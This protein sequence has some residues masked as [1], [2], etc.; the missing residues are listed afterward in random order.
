ML[1][2]LDNNEENL[3]NLEQEINETGTNINVKPTLGDIR[4]RVIMDKL[5]S[6]NRPQVVLHAAAYKHVPM[7]ELNPWY[8]VLT[9]VEGTQ[10]IV[11]LSDNYKV[12]KFILVSTDKAVHPV[13]VMG[14]T[15]RLSERIIQTV[16]KVSQTQYMAVRFGNVIGSSGS[17]IPTLKRQI[18]KGGPI[19]I[20]HPD[21]TRYFM[22]IP[23]A[24]QLIL[25]TGSI[26]RGGEI[27]VLDMGR[28]IKIKN[29]AYDLIRLSGFEPEIEI[30]VIYTGL[31]PGEKM[32][33]ELVTREEKVNKTV[34]PKILIMK[35][36]A[37]K[38]PW[39]DLKID[40]EKL[41]N[42]TLTFNSNS[43]KQKLQQMMPE[44]EPLDYSPPVPNEAM[45]Q[46]LFEIE[47][48]TIKG[49]A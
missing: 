35:N 8:A 25:Q 6:E 44:Y 26:G 9:N 30:P 14:A 29:M 49:Q 5:F 22:S 34:H 2:L 40:I 37:T 27:F 3:F 46:E 28:P 23:E 16:D 32:Y 48:S 42:I 33:E 17:V 21:M 31:R 11:E 24:A 41:I 10:N 7:Q 4:D 19:T 47:K 12:E 45:N 15:K 36:S 38:Q 13:N 20:T 43:I 39:D 18:K 1:T